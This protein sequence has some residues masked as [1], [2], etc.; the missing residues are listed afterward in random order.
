[1]IIV[2]STT[3]KQAEA[4]L[5]KVDVKLGLLIARYSPCSILPHT[6][7][8]QELVESII[9]QQLSVASASSIL[10]RFKNLFGHTFPVPEQILALDIDKLRTAGLSRG[11]ALYIQDL[12]RHV[13]EKK[14]NLS[15]LNTLSNREVVEQLTKVKGIGEWTAHMFLMFAMGRLNILAYGDLG[16]KNGIQKLYGFKTL[17]SVEDIKALSTKNQWAPYETVACWYIW[18]Y[19]ETD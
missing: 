4:Y 13:Q 15:K 18:K 5:T 16:I 6:N 9:S 19:L 8:Y 1:M 3:I 10:K 12:S 17:P 11:K 14:L 7:Y 2:S